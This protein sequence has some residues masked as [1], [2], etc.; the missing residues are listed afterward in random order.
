[1]YRWVEHTA[2]VEL[3]LEA[4]TREQV[5]AEALSAFAE[6]VSRENEGEQAEHEVAVDAQDDATLLA[7]WLGELV[8]LAETEDFV[9][10]RLARFELADGRLEA[11]VSGRRE[12]PAHLVKAVTYHGLELGPSGGIWKAKVV[13]DV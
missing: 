9:P 4:E 2:E 11:V 3:H 10:E 8:F 5:F 12:R 1:M 13:L 7:E 6:L